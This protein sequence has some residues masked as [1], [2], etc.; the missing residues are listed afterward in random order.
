MRDKDRNR[1][2]IVVLL[3]FV[4]M[5]INFADK[6]VIGIAAVPIMQELELG[7]RQFGL[8]GSS[9]FLLFAVSSVTTGFLVNRVP[10]RWV[11]LAMGFIWALIQFPIIG[12]VGFETLVA[13]RIALGPAKVPQ[14]RWRCIPP[15]SGFPTNFAPFRLPSLC[16]AGRSGSWWRCRCSTGSLCVGLGTGPSAHSA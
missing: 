14:R 12:S 6:A 13:C 7:P 5:V 10:T 3:L 9:F 15:T 2:W 1:A 16:K 4:F 11:L 8:L